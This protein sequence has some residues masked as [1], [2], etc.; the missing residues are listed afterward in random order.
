VALAVAVAV[1]MAVAM[2]AVGVSGGWAASPSGPG[3]TWV[4]V[5]APDCQ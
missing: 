1:V 3:D 5:M 2:P 4:F